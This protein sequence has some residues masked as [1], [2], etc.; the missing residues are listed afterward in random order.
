MNE[1]ELVD[2]ALRGQPWA[3]PA[4]V[5]FL[6][7]SLTGYAQLIAPDLLPADQE[8]A[9]QRA[10]E[11]G[12]NRLERYDTTRGTFSGWLRPFVRHAL[13][14]IRR[15]RDGSHEVPLNDELHAHPLAD[16]PPVPDDTPPEH[17]HLKEAIERLSATDQLII[18]LR[19]VEQLTYAQ[20]ATRL[21]V[22][23]TAC[24][25]R[26]HRA[27]ARLADQVQDHPAFRDYREVTT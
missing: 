23:E 2:A 1:R 5:T 12:V 19:D 6:S 14:D 16:T 21:D 11:R 4:L 13:A 26:H 3:G 7:P 27:I 20:I 25:V 17:Q 8:L 15:S 24:R 10:I 9:V 22:S 18:A